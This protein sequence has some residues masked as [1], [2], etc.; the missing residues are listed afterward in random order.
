MLF[1]KHTRKDFFFCE[2][3]SRTRLQ[4]NLQQSAFLD[5]FVDGTVHLATKLELGRFIYT[6]YRNGDNYKPDNE[7]AADNKKN[8][9][10]KM[11]GLL[12]NP[13]KLYG[14]YII[15]SHFNY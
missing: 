1:I 7:F 8:D 10:K 9:E 14:I 2:Q 3:L 6:I 15:N 5:L 4:S 12:D 13:Y 11:E